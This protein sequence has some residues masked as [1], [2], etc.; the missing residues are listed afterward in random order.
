MLMEIQ[1]GGSGARAKALWAALALLACLLLA[2]A[3]AETDGMVRVKLT[4]LGS[5]SALELRADCDYRLASDPSVRVP[6]GTDMTV[7]AS[8]GALT[9]SWGGLFAD[10]GPSAQLLRCESGAH[11]VSFS[12]P[13]LSNRFCGDLYLSASGDVITTVLHIYVEDYLCGVVGCEMAPSS[14]LEALKAQ[15]VV[16]RNYALR[17]KAARVGSAYDLSDSGDAL[18]FRGYSAASEYAD[19]LRAVEATQGLALYYGDDPATCYFCDSN[20]G[21]TESSAN[22]LDAPLPYSDVRDD[23]YDLEGAGPRKTASL[24]KNASDLEPTLEAALIDGMTDQLEALEL[25]T[26]LDAVRIDA[27]REIIP[28]EPRFADPSRLYRSLAFWLDVTSRTAEGVNQSTQ[29]IVIVPTYGALE[30]WYNLAINDGD[31]ETVWVSETDR[32]FEITF[33]RSGSGLGMSQ[34]GAQVMAKKG[35]TCP[36]IL[37]YYYP[38]TEL[39]QLSLAD[40]T[41]DSEEEGDVDGPVLSAPIATAR[42]NQKS[43]LYAR[44]DDGEAAQTTLPAGATVQVYAVQADWAMV[45]SG[46]F[47]GYLHSEVLSSFALSGV[48]AVQVKDETL[49]RISGG[50][51]KLLQLPVDTA[52]ALATLSAGTDVRLEAYTDSWALI[53]TPEGFEGFIHRDAL[54][55]QAEA[56]GEDGDAVVAPDDLYG[57]L[58]ED[59]GLY[60]NADASIAPR[61]AL[62]K[63][64]RV[65]ILAYNRAWAY[66]RT[67]DGRTGYLPLGS[68]SAVKPAQPEPEPE[69]PEGGDV[70]VVKGTEYRYVSAEALALYKSYS[71]NSEVL[72]TL[73]RG[74]KVRLGAYNGVWACVRANGVTGFALLEGLSEDAPDAEEIAV[75]GGEIIRVRGEVYAVVTQDG[76]ALYP[77]WSEADAPLARL[78]EGD[79]VRVGAYNDAWACVEYDGQ[80]GFIPIGL[81]KKAK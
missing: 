62:K 63:D 52:T 38:G 36:E 32:A 19:A 55:L 42:L 24:R 35:F 8:G 53:A 64:E 70:T 13:A 28:Q 34:R 6:A 3:R 33:R 40:A 11:G 16:A 37:E 76:A 10:L 56:E 4:R 48:S 15:A 72:A 5:P 12:A 54:T 57:L 27:I 31:N 67:E 68:L 46:S 17:Q 59:C 73:S 44:P 45:G 81:L 1:R 14:G 51:A 50:P 21:Q 22:A 47:Y 75:E 18:T 43:R 71:T 7:T 39:R 25:S 61:D 9:L 29:V 41:R 26:S 77:S 30:R 78:S 2:S 69:Q 80:R 49:A 74:E 58:T 23:P 65:R 20:G 79:R 60:V 66:V